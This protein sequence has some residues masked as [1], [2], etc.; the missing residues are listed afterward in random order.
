MSD[1]NTDT[2]EDLDKDN[3]NSN[4][5]DNT[6]DDGGSLSKEHEALVEKIV[7]DR[8]KG[9]K[10]NVDKAYKLAEELK[11]EN[12][13][14]KEAQTAA[15]RK[16]LESEGKQAEAD[17]LRIAE[18][19]ELLTVRNTELLGFTRDRQV[20][21]AIS[22]L[23]FRNDY[24]KEVALKDIVNELVQDDDGAWVHKSGASLADY[25]KAFAKDPNREFLFKPKENNGTGSTSPK[26]AANQRPKSVV[27]MSSEEL[28]KAAAAGQLGA[29]F[30]PL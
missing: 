7:N 28:L 29:S 18:L 3:D 23:S 22:A 21:K 4:D 25:V 26:N 20:E 30:S 10:T 2:D 8:L 12:T 5:D 6:N 13:R 14:L 9:M 11:R 1:K 15:E 17:K 16:K 19:E 27:G 24:A